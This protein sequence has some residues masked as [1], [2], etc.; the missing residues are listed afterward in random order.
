MEML[1]VARPKPVLRHVDAMSRVG[2]AL[3][4]PTRV[5]ILLAL[6]SGPVLPSELADSLGVSRQVVSNQLTCLRGCGLVEA[7]RNGRNN[8]YRLTDPHL[9]AALDDLAKVALVVDPNCCAGQDCG[10]C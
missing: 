9:S 7:D 1:A 8:W 3:S 6:R 2:Q 5:R 10:C 4:D